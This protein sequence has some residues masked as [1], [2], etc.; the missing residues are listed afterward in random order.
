MNADGSVSRIL[1]G[2]I[3]I[4]IGGCVCDRVLLADVETNRYLTDSQLEGLLMQ[5]RRSV[6]LSRDLNADKSIGFQTHEG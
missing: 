2:N 3:E 5:P 6:V 4:D 1:T